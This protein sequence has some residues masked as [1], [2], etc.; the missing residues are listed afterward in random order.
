MNA[1]EQI[2]KISCSGKSCSEIAMLLQPVIEI[3]GIEMKENR[4]EFAGISPCV[5]ILESEVTKG[6]KSV[7]P[8]A[9]ISF[10]SLFTARI[11]VLL[12]SG[13][14]YTFS[15]TDNVRTHINSHNGGI[16]TKPGKPTT[17]QNVAGNIW[18][19]LEERLVAEKK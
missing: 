17:S 3:H 8:F 14:L 7:I 6:S 2:S 18:H 10:I 13:E 16:P 11:E 15:K 1:S 5:G 4:F 19:E 12:Q 9:D